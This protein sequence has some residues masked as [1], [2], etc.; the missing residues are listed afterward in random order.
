MPNLEECEWCEG[1]KDCPSFQPMVGYRPG[2]AC[3]RE[4][5][6]QGKHV[7]CTSIRHNVAQW[8]PVNAEAE[9]S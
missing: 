4:A 6:H 9:E 7:T 1:R 3:T 2:Y 5:G 8:D